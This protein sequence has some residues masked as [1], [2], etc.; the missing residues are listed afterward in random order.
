MNGMKTTESTECT[1]SIDVW[2]VWV[3]VCV[4]F[5][6]NYDKEYATMTYIYMKLLIDEKV[7]LFIHYIREIR[8]MYN[9]V[10]HK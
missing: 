3:F 4:F 2:K 8:L 1:L 9:F 6:R 7:N 10:L 5:F